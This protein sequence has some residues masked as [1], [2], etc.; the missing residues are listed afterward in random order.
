MPNLENLR[1]ITSAQGREMGKKG[2]SQKTIKKKIA[3]QTRELK[4][5]SYSDVREERLREMMTSPD[6]STKYILDI[7]Q[8]WYNNPFS[9]KEKVI[10]L[11]ID[12]HKLRH[13]T[14]LNVTNLNIN[15]DMTETMLD[16]YKKR[17]MPADS[18]IIDVTNEV[19]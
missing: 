9:D 8:K 16:A 3:A 10:R 14:K 15:V 19:L 2:G 18:I 13:G 7:L 1:T 5:K 17:K 12:W 11:Y 6:V 4:K